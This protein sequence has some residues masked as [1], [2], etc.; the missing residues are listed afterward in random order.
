MDHFL[1]YYPSKNPKNQNFEKMG[2][3]NKKQ[4]RMEISF[5]TNA[6]KIYY[7]FEFC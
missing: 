3:K 2:E 7:F 4:K 6:P 5:Y 1:P